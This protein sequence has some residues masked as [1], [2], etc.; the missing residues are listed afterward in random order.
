MPVPAKPEDGH[1]HELVVERPDPQQAGD[2]RAEQH[3][4]GVLL[5]GLD[6]HAGGL[7]D[8]ARLVG[9]LLGLPDEEDAQGHGHADEAQS[10][11]AQRQLWVAAAM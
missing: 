2:G 3:L 7:Q 9:P 1:R 5:L 11:S 6:V 8:V 10:Q 4:G